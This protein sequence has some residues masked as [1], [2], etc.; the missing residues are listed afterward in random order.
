LKVVLQ[1]KK[2]KKSASRKHK[3]RHQTNLTKQNRDAMDVNSMIADDRAPRNP[4]LREAD[5]LNQNRN[6]SEDEEAEK[7]VVTAIVCK[8][9]DTSIISSMRVGAKLGMWYSGT[10]LRTVMLES[11]IDKK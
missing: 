7:L 8:C 2:K 3:F 5:A 1:K 11:E 10:G 9:N 4:P 6:D